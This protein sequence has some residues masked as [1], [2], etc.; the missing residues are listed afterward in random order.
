MGVDGRS[1][2]SCREVNDSTTAET[3]EEGDFSL[4]LATSYYY[5]KLMF[6]SGLP[7]WSWIVLLWNWYWY[8]INAPVVEP[9]PMAPIGLR[10]GDAALSRLYCVPS[11]SEHSEAPPELR[12]PQCCLKFHI[13]NS[14]IYRY[15]HQTLGYKKRRRR[16]LHGTWHMQRKHQQTSE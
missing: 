16:H 4:L 2:M 3:W 6:Y 11:V 10:A 1:R 14:Q 15:P 5:M 7:A 8:L 13:L 12:N 9:S